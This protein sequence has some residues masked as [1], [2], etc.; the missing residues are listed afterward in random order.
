M[1]LVL[2]LWLGHPYHEPVGYFDEIGKSWDAVLVVSTVGII[3][4]LLAKIFASNYVKRRA[5][6]NEIVNYAPRWYP[7]ARP[8]LWAGTWVAVIILPVMN[9]LYGFAQ[10]GLLPR[11]ILPWPLNGL[12]AWFM[13]F[14][15]AALVA[16]LAYWDHSIRRGWG[17]GLAGILGEG[18]LLSVSSLSRATYIFTHYLI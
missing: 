3:G 8:W 12:Y 6:G 1:K 5:W 14:G 18:F 2:H 10:V 15:L 17:M 9:L 13:G 4:V 7:F 16:T 11:L